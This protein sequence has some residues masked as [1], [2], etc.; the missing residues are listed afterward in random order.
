MEIQW[1]N[2]AKAGYEA[3]AASTGNK[4]FRGE[5]MPKFEELPESVI[6]AWIAAVCH[7][8]D[9]YGRACTV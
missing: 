3:Y 7:V 6:N 9:L 2:L 1:R 8:C 4:N 5:E